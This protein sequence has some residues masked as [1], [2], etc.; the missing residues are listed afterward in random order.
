MV[1]KLN[2]FKKKI[3]RGIFYITYNLFFTNIYFPDLSK[4]K[5]IL[6]N[7]FKAFS[8]IPL[9]ILFRCLR[10]HIC[11][12]YMKKDAKLTEEMQFKNFQ[13]NTKILIKKKVKLISTPKFDMM[14]R[15]LLH[16]L[17]VS[18]KI[19]VRF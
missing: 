9:S 15:V 10:R 18:G 19:L 4:L 7:L 3:E 12:S 13:K 6:K 2:R 8:K 5:K 17:C 16:M 11:E 14:G 1:K